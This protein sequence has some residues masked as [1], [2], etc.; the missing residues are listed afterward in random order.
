MFDIVIT[1]INS[2]IEISP[3]L[4]ILILV[5]NICGDFLFKEK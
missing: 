2:F 5:F 1:N 4:I 3:I